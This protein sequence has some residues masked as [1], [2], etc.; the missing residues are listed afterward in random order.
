MLRCVVL[1]CIPSEKNDTLHMMS[2]YKHHVRWDGERKE[3]LLDAIRHH[4]SLERPREDMLMN[5][6]LVP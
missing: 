2:Q 3:D 5:D 1:E 6:I 4:V